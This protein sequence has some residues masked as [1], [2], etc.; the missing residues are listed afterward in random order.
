M[1]MSPTAV[2]LVTAFLHGD[3]DSCWRIERE[4]DAAQRTMLIGML[5]GML[6]GFVERSAAH[7]GVDVDRWLAGFGAHVA[8]GG[9]Q[10]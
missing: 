1:D 4:L 5:T 3:F 10:R 9:G 2:A 6:A 7:D 8:S